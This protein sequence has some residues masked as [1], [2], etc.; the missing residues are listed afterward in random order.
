MITDCLS[1]SAMAEIEVEFEDDDDQEEDDADTERSEQYNFLTLTQTIWLILRF[2]AA[3]Q[4]RQVLRL[5][6]N[7]ELGRLFRFVGDDDLVQFE[8]DDLRQG[9]SLFRRA[10][11]APPDPDRFPKVPS[12]EG[13]E[14][15]NSGT[16]GSDEV[17][18]INSGSLLKKKKLASRILDRELATEDYAQQRLNKR[19]MAQVR[20]PQ[21]VPNVY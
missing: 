16:F 18:T 21:L 14:L 11:R 6:A 5:L 1:F 7:T 12:N 4:R 20:F 15:M 13:Q 9:N 2:A 19:L 3:L 10:R 17:Q 8:E